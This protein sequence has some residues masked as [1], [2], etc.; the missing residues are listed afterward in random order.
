MRAIA[1]S[2]L[3]A[4]AVTPALAQ[5]QSPF[6]EYQRMANENSPIELFE[7]LGEGAGGWWLCF[8]G[9]GCSS[10]RPPWRPRARPRSRPS[11][12]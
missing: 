9:G 6:A 3:L 5:K 11:W 8:R 7:I 10:G 1:C 4:L 2:A 12:R